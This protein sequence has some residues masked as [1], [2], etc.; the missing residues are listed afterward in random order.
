MALLHCG[1][2]HSKRNI[3]KIFLKGACYIT[4]SGPRHNC[5]YGWSICG[6]PTCLHELRD[7]IVRQQFYLRKNF[8]SMHK[9]KILTSTIR[10]VAGMNL[11]WPIPV[12]A[13]GKWC[14]GDESPGTKYDLFVLYFVIVWIETG[15]NGE[16]LTDLL[17]ERDCGSSAFLKRR[18]VFFPPEGKI[19][20]FYQ[21]IALGWSK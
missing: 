8:I 20:Q 5:C 2:N 13:I 9:D 6:D 21:Y 1:S 12:S 11:T 3:L 18:N 14:L 19:Q 16:K 7:M 10:F 4:L 17:T 15:R